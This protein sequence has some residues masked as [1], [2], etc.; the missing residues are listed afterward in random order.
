MSGYID[1]NTVGLAGRRRRTLM[2]DLALTIIDRP[3]LSSE[4]TAQTSL[5]GTIYL[6]SLKSP[7]LC[8]SNIAPM[9]AFSRY[10]LRPGPEKHGS[11]SLQQELLQTLP[12]HLPPPSTHIHKEAWP[13]LSRN[14]GSLRHIFSCQHMSYP[15]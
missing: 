8:L 4:L 1:N 5:A 2:N 7:K 9:Q 3:H 12:Y 13:T 11:S 6:P 10:K 14:A 15:E